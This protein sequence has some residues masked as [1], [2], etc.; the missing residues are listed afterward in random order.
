MRFPG[1]VELCAF[2]I[3]NRG[4]RNDIENLGVVSIRIVGSSAE[5]AVR[6]NRLSA[7]ERWSAVGH[8][9]EWV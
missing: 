9:E 5:E 2:E 1:Y 6:S 4:K 7:R 8:V 3:S